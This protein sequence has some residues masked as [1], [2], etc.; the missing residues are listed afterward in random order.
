[1]PT[2]PS[3]EAASPRLMHPWVAPPALRALFAQLGAAVVAVAYAAVSTRE[4]GGALHPIVLHSVLAAALGHALRL[5]LWWLPIN[6]LFLPLAFWAQRLTLHPAWFLV[7]FA[8][9]LAFFWT[10]YRTRVPLYLS[11]RRTCQ[12]LSAFLPADST[13]RVLDLGCGFGGV[14]LTLHR[15]RPDVKLTGLEIAPLPAW[16]A[17]ARLRRVPMADVRRADFWQEDFSQY[18]LVY[19]FLSPEPMSQLWSKVRREMRPGTL[20]VSNAFSIDGVNPD[21]VIPFAGGHR[22]SLYVWRL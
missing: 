22:S 6:A 8:L 21:L 5:P 1:M 4:G 7:G 11:S 2:A 17:R 3:L 20:F 14:L 9:M 16:I 18:D 13:S 19:A 10:T 15:L 12:H